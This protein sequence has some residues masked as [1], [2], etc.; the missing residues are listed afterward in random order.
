MLFQTY[1]RPCYIS[2]ACTFST[3]FVAFYGFPQSKQK[4][5]VMR[6]IV[7]LEDDQLSLS[8][9]D[10]DMSQFHGALTIASHHTCP[11]ATKELQRLQACAVG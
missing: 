8:E 1:L 9:M 10:Q 3:L 7:P 11:Q 2:T 5:E 4:A 6:N